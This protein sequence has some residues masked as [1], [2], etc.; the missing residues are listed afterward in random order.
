MLELVRKD[1]VLH[2]QKMTIYIYKRAGNLEM[3]RWVLFCDSKKVDC[4]VTSL[5][6][7]PSWS[8]ILPVLRC[9]LAPFTIVCLSHL[10]KA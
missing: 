6:I 3:M 1:Y 4:E 7:E 9:L 8:H 5:S 10:F 2:Q